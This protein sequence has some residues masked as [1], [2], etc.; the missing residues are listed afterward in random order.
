MCRALFLF[1]GHAGP[2]AHILVGAGQSVEQG[3]FAAV[4]IARQGNFPLTGVV[5]GG[6]IGSGVGSGFVA[7]GAAH[8]LTLGA[9]HMGQ[10]ALP[11]GFPFAQQAHGDLG[12][13]SLAQGHFIAP[14]RKLHRVAE[15]GDFHQGD[16]GAGGQS[17]VDQ[18]AFH[19][20]GLVGQGQNLTAFSAGQVVQGVHFALG[21][22]GFM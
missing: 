9:V 20:A 3:G 1:Y 2:V 11:E 7:V 12:S 13:V 18:A 15:R 4:G 19:C 22:G 8:T 10:G 16:A 14:Q 6:I 17:H 21:W 5:G